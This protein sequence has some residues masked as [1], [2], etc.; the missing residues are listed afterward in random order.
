M[1]VYLKG[2]T[3]RHRMFGTKHLSDTRRLVFGI[4]VG[5]CL[6]AE[7]LSKENTMHVR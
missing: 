7:K 1:V 4:Q 6:K 3:R 5:Q 2:Y